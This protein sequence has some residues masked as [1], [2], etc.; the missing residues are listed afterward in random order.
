MHSPN[1]PDLMVLKLVVTFSY[2]LDNKRLTDG[3]KTHKTQEEFISR[4][5]YL[6]D[7]IG[8]KIDIV[9]KKIS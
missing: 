3:V 4:R 5:S 8:E 9:L 1:N 7:W 2:F 6:L